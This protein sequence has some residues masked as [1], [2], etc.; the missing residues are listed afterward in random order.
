MDLTINDYKTIL[1][2]YNI[3]YKNMKKN[4][5]IYTGEDILAKKLCRCIKK[6]DYPKKD[7]KR[8]IGI[9]R[10]SVIKKKG[11]SINKFRCKKK[12]RL[13]PFNKTKKKIKK[14]NKRLSIKNIK[15]K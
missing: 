10:N 5:I 13:I 4:K 12:A 3:D 8:A 9:C 15:H 1:D 11:L 7:E 2:Y 14:N 6:V